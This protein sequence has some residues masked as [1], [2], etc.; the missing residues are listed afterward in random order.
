MVQL[1]STLKRAILDHPQFSF[2]EAEVSR[3]SPVEQTIYYRPPEDL[4]GLFSFFHELGHAKLHHQDYEQDIELIRIENEAWSLGVEI[5][6]KY[7]C[8]PPDDIVDNALDSYR[9]WLHAR[10]RCPACNNPGVQQIDTG[11]YSCPLCSTVWRVNDAR[12]CGLKRYT[13]K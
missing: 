9:E 4:Y 13:K 6:E 12:Q 8:S 3:W 1:S 7:G 10:S 2:K 5:A 11:N